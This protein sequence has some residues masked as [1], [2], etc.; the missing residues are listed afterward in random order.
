[1]EIHLSLPLSTDSNLTDNSTWLY[2]CMRVFLVFLLYFEIVALGCWPI[3]SDGFP[4]IDVLIPQDPNPSPGLNP[5]HL[6]SHNSTHDP[7][8]M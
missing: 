3:A 4:Q 2:K 5:T 8:M 7:F 1:M 6:D